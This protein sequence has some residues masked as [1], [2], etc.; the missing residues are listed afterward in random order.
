MKDLL[1]ACGAAQIPLLLSVR[2]EDGRQKNPR[3]S[4]SEIEPWMVRAWIRSD[5]A[6]RLI[7][8]HAD[9]E[10]IEQVHFGATPEE[11]FYVLCDESINPFSE[12]QLG[13]L[14]L[15]IGVSPNYPAE[16]IVV[17]SALSDVS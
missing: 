15:E 11:A 4:S 6:V 13:R 10:F 14:H 1:R 16:F 2:L 12:R 7:V 3:D 9:R 17:V 8:T 5:P